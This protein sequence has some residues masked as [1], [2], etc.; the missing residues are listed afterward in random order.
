ML[1]SSR[2]ATLIELIVTIVIVSIALITLITLT[3]QSEGRSVD[4]MIHE[5]AVAVAQA[6]M[7]EVT[8][9]SYCDPDVATDC[10]TACTSSACGLA[11]CTVAEGPANRDQFDDVCDYDGLS[12][13]GA[14]DQD[15]N[16]LSGLGSYNV[17]VQVVDSVFS[18]GPAGA[19]LSA[20]SGAA[21]RIDVTVSHDALADDI[22]LTGFRTRY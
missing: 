10:A 5:Q 6:Y 17:N 19:P 18:L 13:S 1:N 21:V 12:D 14:K 2:G 22:R 20:A 15:G 7:E 16:A 4:P 3:S 11:T 8:Q 9:K